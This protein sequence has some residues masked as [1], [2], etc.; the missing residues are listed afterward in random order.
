MTRPW[1]ILKLQ[2]NDSDEYFF[3]NQKIFQIDYHP[4]I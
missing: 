3:D 4:V 1:R 2:K